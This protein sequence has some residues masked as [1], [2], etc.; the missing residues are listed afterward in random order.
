MK[1][2]SRSWNIVYFVPNSNWS[3]LV[4]MDLAFQPA[5][6]RYRQISYVSHTANGHMLANRKTV[7]WDHILA[8]EHFM[9]IS[10]M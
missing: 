6:I 8:S 2:H 7:Q 5:S 10:K 3:A 9:K 4:R 1:D